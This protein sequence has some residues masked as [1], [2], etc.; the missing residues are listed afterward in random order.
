[1]LYYDI[2]PNKNKDYDERNAIWILWVCRIVI[3][4]LV[5]NLY[6]N[7]LYAWLL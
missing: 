2:L 5:V 4:K 1:M 7:I 6:I 3:Y